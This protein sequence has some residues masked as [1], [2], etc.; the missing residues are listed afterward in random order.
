MTPND[1]IQ[2]AEQI[3]ALQANHITNVSEELCQKIWDKI[4]SAAEY[5]EGDVDVD[6]IAEQHRKGYAAGYRAGLRSAGH[7]AIGLIKEFAEAKTDPNV[8]LIHS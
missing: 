3:K 2:L 6:A 5:V 4:N 1:L 7:K 8:P